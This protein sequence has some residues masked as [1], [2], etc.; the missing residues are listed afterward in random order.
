[1]IPPPNP[2]RKFILTNGNFINTNGTIRLRARMFHPLIF[3]HRYSRQAI[4]RQIIQCIYSQYGA[5]IFHAWGLRCVYFLVFRVLCL[6]MTTIHWLLLSSCHRTCKTLFILLTSLKW[7]NNFI[8]NN[9]L[10]T[11]V[12]YVC[13]PRSK[14]V[15]IVNR[16]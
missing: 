8:E 16:R 6:K 12:E 4:E 15:Q 9:K 1:M 7:W 5:Y 3:M 11:Y 2:M 14:K 10:Y 13:S